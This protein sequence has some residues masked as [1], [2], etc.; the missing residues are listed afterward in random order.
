MKLFFDDLKRIRDGFTWDKLSK[1]RLGSPVTCVVT[2][3]TE[4]GLETD[5]NGVRGLIPNASL[6]VL[7]EDDEYEVGDSLSAVV[8]FI[9]YQFSVVELSPGKLN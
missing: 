6:A 8:V 4:F 2:E 9:D 5:V 3:V 1:L 7:D